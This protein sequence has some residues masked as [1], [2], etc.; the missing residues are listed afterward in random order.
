MSGNEWYTCQI[1]VSKLE[2]D[3][4]VGIQE[5]KREDPRR[6]LWSSSSHG[7]WDYS[8]ALKRRGRSD[9]TSRKDCSLT[10]ASQ[11]KELGKEYYHHW[12]RTILSFQVTLK[13]IN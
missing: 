13:L 9:W 12:V 6:S 2:R 5:E 4:I 7:V 10:V 11:E 1:K 3:I 8:N